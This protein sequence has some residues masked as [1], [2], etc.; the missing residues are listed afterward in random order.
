MTEEKRGGIRRQQ[1]ID[2]KVAYGNNEM[3]PIRQPG[4]DY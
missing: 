1:T 2:D 3:K 4:N